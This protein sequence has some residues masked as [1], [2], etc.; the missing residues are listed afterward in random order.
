M[1]CKI[2]VPFFNDRKNFEAFLN[3]ISKIDS[4]EKYF[5]LLDNGSEI[6][7]FKKNLKN[8]FDDENCWDLIRSEKNLGFGGGVI[9][10]AQKINEDFVCWMPGNMKV[11]P[12]EVVELIKKE[13]Y[14]KI[15]TLLKAK[16]INRPLVDSL[17]TKVFSIVASIKFQKMM[18]DVG[19]TPN[20]ISKE[21]LLGIKNYPNDFSFDAFIYYFAL[22]NKLMIIRPKISY[23]KRLHGKSHWQNGFKAEVILTKKIFNSKSTWKK[24]ALEN[25]KKLDV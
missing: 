18:F 22:L 4:N 23:T 1:N 24:I 17:K 6:P 2:V 20:I 12:N 5:L 13:E 19:G 14:K 16:R 11:K 25:I 9:Y 8:Y 7:L 3:E 21:L 15:N 10:A